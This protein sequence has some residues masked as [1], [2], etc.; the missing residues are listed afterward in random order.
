MCGFSAWVTVANPPRPRGAGAAEAASVTGEDTDSRGCQFA[1]FL[2][3]V[4]G[5]STVTVP[6]DTG[7]S[8]HQG[9]LAKRPRECPG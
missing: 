7:F 1:R 3:L 5:R 6:Q 2:Q 8:R 9:H 4:K